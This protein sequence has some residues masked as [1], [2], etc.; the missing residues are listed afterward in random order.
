MKKMLFVGF[1]ILV[2]SIAATARV[3]VPEIDAGSLST[4]LALVG[5]GILML[6]A[7]SRSK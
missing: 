5:G 4:V 2:C 7:K 1:C 6:R 3:D